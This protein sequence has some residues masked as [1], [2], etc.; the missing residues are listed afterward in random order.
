MAPSDE[1]KMAEL[2]RLLRRLD[3]LDSR[4][5]AGAGTNEDAEQRDYVGTLRGALEPEDGIAPTAEKP[6]QTVSPRSAALL[7]GVIAALISTATVYVLMSAEQR[8]MLPSSVKS[9]GMTPPGPASP[10]NDRGNTSMELVRNAAI[11]LEQGNIDG[12]REL[13][14]RAA[15]LGSGAAALELARTYDPGAVAKPETPPAT[16]E[17]NPA[18]ARVWYDRARELGMADAAIPPQSSGR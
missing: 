7:A 2:K 10:I 17:T 9:F 3:G 11:L 12:A 15:E 5:S 14:H 13:L 18:L 8:A 6:Q 4:R 16:R 1:I